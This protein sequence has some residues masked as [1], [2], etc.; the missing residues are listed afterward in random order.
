GSRESHQ[1]GEANRFMGP[2]PNNGAII[3]EP[4]KSLEY[5]LD[6]LIAAIT[7]E[8]MHEEVDFGE[9]AGKEAL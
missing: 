7:P 9:P 5:D 3:I 2:S 6:E 4:I 8:N 1:A